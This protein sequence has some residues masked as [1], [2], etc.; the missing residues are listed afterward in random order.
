MLAFLVAILALTV[1]I[2]AHLLSTSQE[3][4]VLVPTLKTETSLSSGMPSPAYLEMVT[5]DTASLFLNRHPNNLKYFRDNILRMAHPS[6]H[7]ELESA[8]LATEK[9]LIATQTSTTFFPSE[10]ITDP[11]TNYTEIH[12]R[13]HTYLGNER[14]K[15]ERMIFGADWTYDS[16]RLWL[17]D[18]YPIDPADSKSQHAELITEE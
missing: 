11:Q 2:L 1:L 17:K 15:D 7:G 13:L 4:I 10:I 5:R 3:R 9:R 18:F 12:G 8:L 16:M 6:S 14:I